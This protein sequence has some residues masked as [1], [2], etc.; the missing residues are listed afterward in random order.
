MT[1]D[2][3]LNSAAAADATST[4]TTPV[5]VYDSL[6]TSHILTVTFQKTDVNTWSYQ[7]SIPGSDVTAGTAGTPYDIPGASGTLT[8]DTNGQLT[9]PAAGS[10]ISVQIPGLSDGA[11][12]LNI[13]WD[14]YNNGVGRITQFGQAS[15]ASASSQDGI[16]AAELVSVSIAQ[17][18]A[19]TAQ[20]SNGVQSIVGQLAMAAI[21]NPSTLVDAGT[22]N[23]QLS[24]ASADPSVGVPG[25]GG[26]GTV[27]GE[28]LEA[29]NVDL[30]TQ[31]TSLINYQRSYEANAHVVTTADQLSQDTINLIH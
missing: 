19:I 31:F 27:V 6:G 10:P 8:F 15:A 28:A 13:A 26:R 1:V 5:T 18:G 12:D 25:T 7:V 21:S 24:A 9:S 29:S 16:S 30:G 17:G 4:F 22:N 23:F 3:N 2:L 11:T 20:Y 14:P